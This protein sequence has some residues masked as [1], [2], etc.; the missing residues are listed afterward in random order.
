MPRTR[1]SGGLLAVPLAT[2]YTV[3]IVK[4]WLT[5]DPRVVAYVPLIFAGKMAQAVA[6]AA[7][8]A[9]LARDR[10]RRCRRATPPRSTTASVSH[11]LADD[12]AKQMWP[13]RR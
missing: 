8:S 2:L 6:M 5:R 7:Y 13:A 10:C 3:F 12:V 11:E 9:S 1:W 4:E